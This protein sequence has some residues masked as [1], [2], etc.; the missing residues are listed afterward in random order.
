MIVKKEL[1]FSVKD[2]HNSHIG[3]IITPDIAYPYKKRPSHFET[4]L[5]DL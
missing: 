5:F 2:L 3:R 4:A 1:H